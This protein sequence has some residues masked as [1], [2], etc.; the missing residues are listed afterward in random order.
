MTEA[1]QEK[2]I[3]SLQELH[4]PRLSQSEEEKARGEVIL[5]AISA[6]LKGN[7][8][9]YDQAWTIQAG[10]TKQARAYKAAFAC[11]PR[12]VKF[13]YEGRLTKQVKDEIEA[14]ARRMAEQFCA[15]Y[16]ATI[17]RG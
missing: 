17:D 1:R 11:V 7:A 3:K 8:S 10:R 13:P 15:A 2:N 5:N 16:R 12:P 6:A 14:R 4:R 9:L